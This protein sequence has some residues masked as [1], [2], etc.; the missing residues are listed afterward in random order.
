MFTITDNYNS[1]KEL[2]ITVNSHLVNTSILGSYPVEI[3]VLDASKNQTTRQLMVKVV[4]RILQV[5]HL[6]MIELNL[7]EALDLSKYFTFK[8]NY[9]EVLRYTS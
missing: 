4:D 7:G 8:D 5:L 1:Q 6:K 9:D 3:K 2:S